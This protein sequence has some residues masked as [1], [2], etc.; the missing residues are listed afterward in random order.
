MIARATFRQAFRE[1]DSFARRSRQTSAC[2]HSDLTAFA[3]RFTG[4]A[5]DIHDDTEQA[6]ERIAAAVIAVNDERYFM[7][8]PEE[9][10]R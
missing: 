9:T 1:T 7:A 6:C 5:F 8:H 10:T 3:R 2:W 4:E